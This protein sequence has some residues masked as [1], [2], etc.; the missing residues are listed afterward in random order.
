MRKLSPRNRKL[1]S[2]E[3]RDQA[4]RGRLEAPVS[5]PGKECQALTQHRFGAGRGSVAIGLFW[6]LQA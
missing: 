5:F 3:V 1:T 2:L 6:L 4:A